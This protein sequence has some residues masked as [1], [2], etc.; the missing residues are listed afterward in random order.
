M[1]DRVLT[2]ALSACFA[3]ALLGCDGTAG[4][5]SFTDNFDQADVDLLYEMFPG[6]NDHCAKILLEEER[7]DDFPDD[8]R[9]CFEM[10]EPKRWKGLWLNGFEGSRFCPEPLSEC[11]YETPGD[12]I[13][14][15][16][17]E[18]NERPE[19]D[20]DDFGKVYEIEFVGPMT[21]LRGSHGHIGTSDHVVVVERLI[22]I[23]EA[24][25]S[26]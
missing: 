22:R 21:A 8:V 17:D 12:K 26:E 11:A 3:F 9:A 15:T 14:L 5:S 2:T 6:I 25:S 1:F 19:L 10:E 18:A 7:F 24:D 23:D 13:W 16:F 4:R 20:D